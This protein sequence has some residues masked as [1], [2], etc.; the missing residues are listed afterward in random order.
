MTVDIKK[1]FDMLAHSTVLDTMHRLDVRGQPFNIT[2]ALLQG[3]GYVIKS[4]K[5]ES[6][7]KRNDVGVPQEQCCRR[8][9][10]T[11]RWR[12]SPSKLSQIFNLAYT[13][14]ADD[15]TMWTM[16]RAADADQIA[17]VQRGL[18]VADGFQAGP[19]RYATITGEDQIHYVCH[20]L[21]ISQRSTQFQRNE[22]REDD[23]A[24]NPGHVSS[25]GPGPDD[26]DTTNA[27]DLESGPVGR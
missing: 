25:S 13:V 1:A 6:S 5:P 12:C 10:L 14:Y 2:K 9:S 24:H 3:R 27:R 11:W 15:T 20:W 4:G 19:I 26:L 18:D 23:A 8:R 22:H 7:E 16:T 17:K 21:G